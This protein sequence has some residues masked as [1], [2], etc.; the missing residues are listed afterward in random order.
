MRKLHFNS[1]SFHKSSLLEIS[2][3]RTDSVIYVKSPLGFFGCIHSD[4]FWYQSPISSFPSI[5]SSPDSFRF[6][7]I[8]TDSYS[9]LRFT[10]WWDLTYE[11]EY[12]GITVEWQVNWCG[13]QITGR[14]KGRT[15]EIFL[16]NMDI[17]SVNLAGTIALDM[18]VFQDIA[19]ELGIDL[20]S[21]EEKWREGICELEAFLVLVGLTVFDHSR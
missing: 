13:T 15:E 18:D 12:R 19:Q 8:A 11:S 3:A 16:L 14:V 17:F 2:D 4:P 20:S 21:Q 6:I 7:N 9:E 5:D 10:S 1:T